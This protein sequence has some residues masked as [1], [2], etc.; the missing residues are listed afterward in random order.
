MLLHED[1]VT[2]NTSTFHL[3]HSG[4][5]LWH[6]A[7]T[8]QGKCLTAWLQHTRRRQ[9]K[10]EQY[11]A[12]LDDR[13]HE[14]IKIGCRK[15]LQYHGD[16]VRNRTEATAREMA[17][18]IGLAALCSYWSLYGPSEAESVNEFC[19]ELILR[20]YLILPFLC[21][22]TLT[23]RCIV[24][25]YLVNGTV[26]QFLFLTLQSQYVEH[27]LACKY[28]RKWISKVRTQRNQRKTSLSPSPSKYS[29]PSKHSRVHQSPRKN[30]I[31]FSTADSVVKT[32]I[33]RTLPAPRFP[34]FLNDSLQRDGIKYTSARDINPTTQQH[35]YRPEEGSS[36]RLEHSPSKVNF[37]Q[38]PVFD[39]NPLKPTDNLLPPPIHDKLLLPTDI[40][41]HCN[42]H[43][44]LKDENIH[45]NAPHSGYDPTPSNPMVLLPPS[46]F[47]VS[48]ASSSN[49][50]FSD[51][52]HHHHP[53][54]NLPPIKPTDLSYSSGFGDESSCSSSVEGNPQSDPP[55]GVADPT[56]HPNNNSAAGGDDPFTRP[57]ASKTFIVTPST[58]PT[59]QKRDSTFNELSVI[60][61]K[62][63]E[64]QQMK[65]QL[66]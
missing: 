17:Q 24:N 42:N 34:D 38:P 46:A 54:E 7:L 48:P 40:Q 66:K 45:D 51:K 5:A 32:P 47:T 43:Y 37:I 61:Q 22:V 28:A 50:R 60:R 29:S 35:C 1:D 64:F 18:V 23:P 30:T 31:P 41:H 4:D 62:L 15:L 53:D 12:V 49:S 52:H 3:C 58:G 9:Q 59:T 63:Q 21:N 33:V 26:F 65:G 57:A 20:P 36:G 25:R 10:R 2:Y 55:H 16:A 11:H 56:P 39:N 13:R 27:H 6:W 19:F 44:L 8:L 14:M